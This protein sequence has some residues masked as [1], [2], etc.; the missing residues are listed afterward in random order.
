M[1]MAD[2]LM[3]LPGARWFRRYRVEECKLLTMSEEALDVDL[4]IDA[5][6]DYLYMVPRSNATAM[7]QHLA[8]CK[9]C[10]AR[11]QRVATLAMRS[12]AR[13]HAEGGEIDPPDEFEGEDS[14]FFDP[15]ELEELQSIATKEDVDSDFDLEMPYETADD[16]ADTQEIRL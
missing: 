10:R 5:Y 4:D 11:M 12:R 8:I 1:D 2:A 16:L 7:M 3:E 15:E 6:D 9:G 13:L 14:T